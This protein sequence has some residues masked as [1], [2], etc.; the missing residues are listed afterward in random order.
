MCREAGERV[1]T[2]VRV[3]DLDLPPRA[4]ADNRRLEVVADGL[5]LF[6]GAQLA[7]DTTM[8]SPVRRDVSPRRQCATRDGAAMAQGRARKERTYPELAQA[9]GRAR[10]GGG[11]VKWAPGDLE[12]PSLFSTCWLTQ[13]CGMS[14]RTSGSDQERVDE[15]VDDTDGVRSSKIFCAVPSRET[16][17]SGL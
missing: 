7:I 13:R 3:Q 15:K 4:G 2:N 9:N 12:R 8:V 1:T 5:P 6:H 11:C 10:F 16:L 17:R 14:Q